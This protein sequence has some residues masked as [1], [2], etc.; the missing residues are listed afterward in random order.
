MLLLSHTGAQATDDPGASVEEDDG[1]KYSNNNSDRCFMHECGPSANS[2]LV[3]TQEERLFPC[4]CREAIKQF[5][6]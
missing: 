6:T 2:E 4:H 3:V 1:Q 5:F